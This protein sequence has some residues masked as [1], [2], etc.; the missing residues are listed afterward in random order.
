MVHLAWPFFLAFSGWKRVDIS[1]D[2][3]NMNQ[4]N[5][6]QLE[7]SPSNELIQPELNPLI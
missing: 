7:L 5:L 4:L 2:Q 1:N 3:I 6:T